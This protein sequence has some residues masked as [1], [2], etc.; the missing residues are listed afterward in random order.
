LTLGVVLTL[1]AVTGGRGQELSGSVTSSNGS[2][3]GGLALPSIP[4]NWADLPVKLTASETVTYNSNINSLPI[5]VAV[6]GQVLGD[7]TSTSNFGFS[8]TANV[9]GHQ[10][11]FDATF[12][13]IRYVHQVA[14]NSTVYSLNAG[15][16]WTV[17]S[18]C[19]GT[20]GVSL[21]K[22]PVELTDLVGVGVN[23]ATT[24]ALNETG[25]CSVSNG[26]SLVFNSGLTTTTNSNPIDAVNDARTTLL[27]AGI[28][29]AKGYSTLTALAS[30]SDSN[31]TGRTATQ[32]AL[33]LETSTAFH[34]FS[35]NYSR[36]INANLSV[37]GTVGLVGTSNGFTLALPKSLLPIYSL[38][39]TWAFTP[40]LS[41]NAS[42]SRTVAAPT[43]VIANAQTSYDASVGLGYQM[44]PKVSVSAGGSIDYSTSTFTSALAQAGFSPF[45]VGTQKSYTLNAGLSYVMTPFLSAGLNASYTERVGNGFIT[46]QD[47]V[48]VSLNYRPY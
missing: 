9:Y 44:T 47:L 15:V 34:S 6:P 39:T 31:F 14:F 41:L 7:F 18:R 16:D 13:V 10:L 42:A 27:S 48:T 5:G 40:K 19:S 8:S 1:G 35:L 4:E 33:G 12:G 26:Y 30:I 46:P 3:F 32:A 43:T 17:T 29:Y 11:F 45:F 23:Y 20:L 28:E 36:Q 37:R 25:R 24:T 2:P 21:S 22:S 38:S